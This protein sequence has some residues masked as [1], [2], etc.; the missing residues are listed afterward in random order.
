MRRIGIRREDKTPW[1]A[2]V[3]LIPEHVGELIDMH[4]LHFDVQPSDQR[5]FT[6]EEFEEYGATASEDFSGCDII[7]GV[8]EVPPRVIAPGKTYVFFSHTIKGQARNMPMLRRMMDLGCNLIDYEKITDEEGRRLVFF[9]YYAGLAG[10]IDTL[11][12][13][14]RRWAAEGIETPLAQVTPAHE[15]ESLAAAKEHLAEV[16]TEMA[17]AD[18]PAGCGPVVC[19][20]AG[21]GQVSR[22]AQEIYDIFVPTQVAPAELAGLEADAGNGRFYKVVFKEEHMV[23][24]V[25]AS[26]SFALRDYY[27]HPEKYRGVFAQYLPHLTV[28]VNCIYWE[29]KYPRLVTLDDVRRLYAAGDRP[30]LKVIGDISCDPDGSVQCTVKATDPGNP[31]YVYDVERGAA[32]DGFEGRG[33]VMMAVEILPSELPRESSTAFSHALLPLMP[34]LAAADPSGDFEGWD[35]PGPLKRAVILH[36]GKLTPPFAYLRE[37]LA[38]S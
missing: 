4:G 8:K 32:R 28:L 19:G 2:R 7:L 18:A 27:E 9:G 15:Y 11:W 5:V 25:A 35:L 24:P 6:V 37:F 31:V 33:P 38:G 29:P 10:M 3:P 17:S 36:K 12:A 30:R 22:G 23:T 34:G 16:A 21:Y 14:G 1:E 20:F 26:A 13:L